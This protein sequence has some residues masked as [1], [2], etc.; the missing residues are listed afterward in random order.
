MPRIARIVAVGFPHHI[1]QRG[2]YKQEIFEDEFDR[3]EYL[4]YIAAESRKYNVEILA[5]CLMTNHVHFILVPQEESSL[6]Q[7]FKYTNMKYSS[8]FNRKKGEPG[9]LFQG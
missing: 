4:E 2:N 9:H 5:Y 3:R 7:V 1:T 6:G 8:Y